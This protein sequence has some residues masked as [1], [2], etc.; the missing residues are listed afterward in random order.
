M[1]NRFGSTDEVAI[2]EMTETG[3]KPVYDLKERIMKSTQNH[4]PGSV[5]TVA[6]DNG[7]PVVVHL[8]VLLNKTQGKFPSRQ[9]V[10]V[11]AKRVDLIIA[12]LERYLK[13]NL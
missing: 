13:A 3:M 5:F 1:K 7:R 8:E 9:V 6:I 2:F 10:G 12:I 11:D 4:I